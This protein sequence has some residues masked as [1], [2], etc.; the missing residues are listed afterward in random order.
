M[1]LEALNVGWFTAPAGLWRQGEDMETQMRYPIPAYVI[2]TEQE[3]ILVD[4]GLH[5]AAVANAADHYEAEDALA[6]FKLELEQ[7]IAEQLE[8]ETIT[9]VILTH[10]H[11]DHAGALSLLPASVPIFIQRREW[12]AGQSAAAVTKNFYMP[13]DYLAVAEQVSLVD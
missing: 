3:R 13:K 7:S 2:E 6:L 11:W 1:K 9:K 10:L 12:E 4:T 8:L 5:P